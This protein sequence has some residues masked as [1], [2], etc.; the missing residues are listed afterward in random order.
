MN[1]KN[2]N[3]T[4]FY[5]ICS[6]FIM[7]IHDKLK[8]TQVISPFWEPALVKTLLNQTCILNSVHQCLRTQAILSGLFLLYA[9]HIQTWIYDIPVCSNDFFFYNKKHISYWYMT[10]WLYRAQIYL[11]P[12]FIFSPYIK[13][14]I[15]YH[16][17]SL[18]P[19]PPPKKIVEF[20]FFYILY[21]LIFKQDI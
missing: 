3:T 11:F 12:L 13:C 5:L 16:F 6:F 14:Y 21:W 2:E 9:V 19:P 20:L 4:F 18:P 17:C 7:F 15:A 1:S 10:N 8:N